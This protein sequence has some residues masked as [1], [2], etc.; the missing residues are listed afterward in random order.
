MRKTKRRI[1]LKTSTKKKK[2]KRY[3]HLLT[4]RN[5]LFSLL[6]H[7]LSGSEACESRIY[8]IL[9]TYVYRERSR[10]RPSL[11]H[12]FSDD[13]TGATSGRVSPIDYQR[14][15]CPFIFSVKNRRKSIERSS[16][17]WR[18]SERETNWEREECAVRIRCY[19]ELCLWRSVNVNV[20]GNFA[21]RGFSI[22]PIETIDIQ[23]CMY[24]C[25]S[26]GASGFH[27]EC[28]NE[29]ETIF[30]NL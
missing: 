8:I 2:R 6:F 30:V 27:S 19:R 16:F 26:R 3:E 22:V 23:V 17:V 5:V 1:S 20:N 24:T 14:E 28:R 25:L 10:Q 12:R 15:R 13:L 11:L 4:K 21:A 7:S 9:P 29:R 18:A